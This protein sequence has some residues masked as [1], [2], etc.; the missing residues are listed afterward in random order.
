MDVMSEIGGISTP[1]SWTEVGSD[2]GDEFR[3]F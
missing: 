2:S 3:G 1:G